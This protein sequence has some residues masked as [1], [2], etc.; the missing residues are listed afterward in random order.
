MKKLKALIFGALLLSFGIF[1]SCDD[2]GVLLLFT[3][4]N[5]KTLGEQVKSEIASN[6][7]EFPILE[8]N[9]DNEFAYNVLD[10]M[11]DEILASEAVE[12]SEQFDWE[13]FII[14]K[15]DVLNAFATPGGKIYVYTGLIYFLTNLDD[16]MGVL[17]HEVAHADLRHSS[18]Q[19]QQQYTIAGLLAILTGGQSESIQEIAGLLA[20]LGSLRF[21][22]GAEAEADDFSVL[23]LNDTKYACNGAAAFFDKIVNSGDPRGPEFLSTH[24]D[25]G[26]R[27]QDIN[28]KAS[29]VGCE[30]NLFDSD[31][32]LLQALQSTLPG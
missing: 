25:P 18:K 21:S 23:Y 27:V 7:D 9:S 12:F 11:L 19:L 30:T 31:K 5:D 1:S 20:N 24:P 16:L 17:G 8:R 10:E 26:N 13:L 32:S 29:E 22:R 28:D 6:P 15:P 14:D 4:E 2:N 3:I